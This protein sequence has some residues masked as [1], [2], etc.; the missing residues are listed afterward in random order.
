M[1]KNISSLAL[2]VTKTRLWDGSGLTLP[3]GRRKLLLDFLAAFDAAWMVRGS[4]S[5]LDVIQM[6]I[7]QW[8]EIH[9][10]MQLERRVI[11]FKS[12]G[13]TVECCLRVGSELP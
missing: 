7:W 8:M 5:P 11:S 1:A 6:K 10:F 3:G 4:R 12:E 9:S 13:K 2:G